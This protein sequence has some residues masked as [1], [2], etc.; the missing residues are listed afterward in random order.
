MGKEPTPSAT[1]TQPA[2]LTLGGPAPTK[3]RLAGGL[4]LTTPPKQRRKEPKAAH[5]PTPVRGAR[6][7]NGS[8]GKPRAQAARSGAKSGDSG[9]D[10]LDPP[11]KRPRGDGAARLLVDLVVG[12]LHPDAARAAAAL[13][14][15]LDEDA[16]REAVS[17]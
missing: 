10:G 11:A 8:S 17:S 4:K 16:R 6:R 12:G 7:V 13:V 15:R 5:V 2:Y 14:I 9:E 3:K 1:H